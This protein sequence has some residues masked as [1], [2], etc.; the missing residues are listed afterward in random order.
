[1]FYT[2]YQITNL[3]NGKIYIGM[4]QTC[5]LDDGYMGSGKLLK[6]AIEKY[7]IENFIKEILFIF[8]DEVAMRSKEIELV[9]ENFIKRKDTYN[10]C[11]GGKG[12]FGYINSTLG[13]KMYPNRKLSESHKKAI[14]ESHKKLGTKPPSNLGDNHWNGKSHTEEWKENHSKI[15]KE[16]SKG[17]NNSQ[18]GTIWVTDG[19]VN[20][21]IK[22]DDPIPESFSKGRNIV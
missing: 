12:G 5:N 10:L 2:I 21:K 19:I 13:I 4:H 18:F 9:N 20:K 15:M 16:K 3:V 8:D 6:K 11:S 17:S 22:K 7:G 14:S 1:M